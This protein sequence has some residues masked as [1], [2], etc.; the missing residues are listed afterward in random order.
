MIAE[1][2]ASR[3]MDHSGHYILLLAVRLSTDVEQDYAVRSV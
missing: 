2:I 1:D 3:E